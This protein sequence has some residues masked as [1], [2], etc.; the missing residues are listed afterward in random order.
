MKIE[1]ANIESQKYIDFDVDNHRNRDKIETILNILQN[2]NKN[3]KD[4]GNDKRKY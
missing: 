2:H 3:G 4:E 1:C